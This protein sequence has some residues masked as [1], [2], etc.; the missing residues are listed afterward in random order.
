MKVFQLLR[1]LT[2]LSLPCYFLEVNAQIWSPLNNGVD[3]IVWTIS[4]YN[5]SLIMGG[6]FINADGSQTN[7][8]ASWDGLSWNNLGSGTDSNGVRSAVEFLNDLYAAGPFTKAGGQITGNISKWNGSQW[9]SVGLPM[10]SMDY[11]RCLNVFNGDLYIG[12]S[13]SQVGG[14]SANSIASWDGINWDSLGSGIDGTVRC[15]AVYNGALYV[16]G[17]FSS[18]GGLPVNDLARWDG[19]QWSLFTTGVNGYVN[20]LYVS[21]TDLYI[22]GVF[23]MIN[24]I[25]VNNIAKWDG[26]QFYSLG[27]GLNS[28]NSEVFSLASFQGRIFAGGHFTSAG[29]NLA[30]S[31]ASFDG[32]NWIETGHVMFDTTY[33]YVTSLF[34]DSTNYKLY[35]GGNFNSIDGILANNIAVY[36][37]TAKINTYNIQVNDIKIYS[38]LTTTIIAFD[39][40]NI[41]ENE[42]LIIRIFNSQA[43]ILLTKKTKNNLTNLY[44]SN[45]PNGIYYISV[46]RKEESICI[47][48]FI[49]I[50]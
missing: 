45:Y 28:P 33:G 21:G 34:V 29:G 14:I 13:F 37:L 5:N 41:P 48:K 8:I 17:S 31:L 9:D 16:G 3:G 27:T 26:V 39:I 38:S 46:V 4:K 47:K 50:N 36:D 32:I 15:M 6:D 12:G 35:T 19:T 2:C 22:G 20:C 24:S 1:I 43:D 49:Y 7:G 25:P 11:P 44:F 18:A 10:F 30:S 42:D 40:E 23:S